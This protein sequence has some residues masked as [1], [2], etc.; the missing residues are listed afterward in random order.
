MRSKTS[1]DSSITNAQ[2]LKIIKPSPTCVLSD[3]A[4]RLVFIGTGEIDGQNKDRLFVSERAPSVFI[5]D[6]LAGGL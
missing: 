1:I 2:T 3:D 6:M 4:A 5:Q